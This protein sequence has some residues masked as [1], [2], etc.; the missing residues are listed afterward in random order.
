MSIIV[1]RLGSGRVVTIPGAPARRD[2][3]ASPAA[4]MAPP[5]VPRAC[6]DNPPPA[7]RRSSCGRTPLRFRLSAP[8]SCR[9][10]SEIAGFRAAVLK[11]R[12]HLPPAK[13]LLRTR[14]ATQRSTT[15]DIGPRQ[16]SPRPRKAFCSSRVQN[17]V[18]GSQ[19]ADPTRLICGGFGLRAKVSLSRT[20][21]C[22]PQ[23]WP[24]RRFGLRLSVRVFHQRSEIIADYPD[25]G[26]IRPKALLEDR[27]SPTVQRL[28]LGLPVGR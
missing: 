21:L 4:A 10:A 15:D 19:D 27:H 5:P 28:R 12:I 16:G 13:S 20:R 22:E 23:V 3:P 7:A 25:I 24:S 6:R 11:V 26:M 8:Q 14:F 17:R 9:D 18:V 2:A 1:C